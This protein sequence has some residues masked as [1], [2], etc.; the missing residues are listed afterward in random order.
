MGCAFAQKV[1]L[2]SAITESDLKQI[3]F[4]LQETILMVERNIRWIK[5][6]SPI[7]R[8]AGMKPAGDDGTFQFSI[9]TD[10]K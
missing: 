6:G 7:K 4:K 3:C 1:P 5:S 2:V 9:Y 10:T 8:K